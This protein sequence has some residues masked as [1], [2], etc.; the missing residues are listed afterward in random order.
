MK[1]RSIYTRFQ[2]LRAGAAFLG[3]CALTGLTAGCDNPETSLTIVQIQPLGSNCTVSTS[4]SEFMT[5]GIVDVAIAR[6]YTL[7]PLVSN[8]MIDLTNAKGYSDG[9]GRQDTH[10]VR[11]KEVSYSIKGEIEGLDTTS[12]T[13]KIS[14]TIPVQS[15]SVVGFN[16]LSSEL[17]KQIREANFQTILG[18]SFSATT[19]SADVTISF[20][21]KGETL[22]GNEVETETYSFP[23][24]ICSGC[25]INYP[26]D[27]I[28]LS[29]QKQPNCLAPSDS[30][31]EPNCPM[32]VGTDNQILDCRLC[33]SYANDQASRALCQP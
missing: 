13:Q 2:S 29:A 15:Q 14:G 27:A 12:F 23:L 22:D 9:D 19:G 4:E 21:I 10:A 1:T 32:Q 26:A 31:E 5:R 18:S 28:D 24:E 8:N 20:S 25:L 33:P 6:R 11:L 17:I 7:Y 30:V 16:I 3:A